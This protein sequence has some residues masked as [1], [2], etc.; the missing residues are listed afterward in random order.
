M[1][2]RYSIS[3]I[4]TALATEIA[5]A[6]NSTFFTIEIE[7]SEL[8]VDNTYSVKGSFKDVAFLSN[9]ARRK[10][11]FEAKLDENLKIVNLKIT[12]DQQQ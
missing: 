9:I 1:Q 8:N 7:I 10:G 5:A 4:K 2:N 3:N 12:E 11:K 6:L